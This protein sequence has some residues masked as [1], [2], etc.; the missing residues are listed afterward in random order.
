[1][2]YKGIFLGTFTFFI[3]KAHLESWWVESLGVREEIFRMMN[4]SEER[5]NFPTSGDKI[6]FKFYVFHC[7]PECK[8]Q[9]TCTSQCLLYHLGSINV[10]VK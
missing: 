8:W 3:C 4:T 10:H 7:F 2:V 9:Y 5:K 6:A 1:M